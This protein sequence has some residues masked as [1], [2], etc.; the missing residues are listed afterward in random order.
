MLICETDLPGEDAFGFCAQLKSDWHTSQLPIVLLSTR[1][2]A[3]HLEMASGAGADDYLPKPV[4][5]NDVDVAVNDRLAR[6]LNIA[7]PDR[8]SLLKAVRSNPAEATP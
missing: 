2:A 8:A 1:P 5:V 4:F 6:S 3:F 7:V